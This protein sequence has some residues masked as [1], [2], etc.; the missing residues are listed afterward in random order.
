MQY[1]L[2]EEEYAE[3]KKFKEG[4]VET[5]NM[6]DELIKFFMNPVTVNIFNTDP[7]IRHEPV[8]IGAIFKIEKM[9]EV[10]KRRYMQIIEM[11]KRP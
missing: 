7:M 11:H 5:E 3:Y 10:V 4:N 9:P 8:E 1:L 6:N 2:T